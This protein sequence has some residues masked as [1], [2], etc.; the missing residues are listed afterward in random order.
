[1]NA[2]RRPAE[3]LRNVARAVRASRASA[4]TSPSNSGRRF[5]AGT[6][7][8]MIAFSV[9]TTSAEVTGVPSSQ[10]ACGLSRIVNTRWSGESETSSASPGTRFSFSS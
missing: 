9:K 8:S 3:A 2:S 4:F 10:R 7:G 1:M 5:R 6:F